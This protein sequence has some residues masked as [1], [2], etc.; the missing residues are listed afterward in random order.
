MT[1]SWSNFHISD[2]PPKQINKLDNICF[3]YKLKGFFLS[4]CRPDISD[5]FHFRRLDLILA[6]HG[7]CFNVKTWL[8]NMTSIECRGYS[9]IVRNTYRFIH[10][11]RQRFDVGQLFESPLKGCN[12][13]N[14]KFVL[15]MI[16]S[17]VCVCHLMTYRRSVD[18]HLYQSIMLFSD[19]DNNIYHQRVSRCIE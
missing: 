16:I 4:Q 19:P 14:G 1:V 6:I 3:E 11:S 8:L 13:R 9:L 17:C 15:P 7:A 10:I 5:S 12:L 2:L 18:K